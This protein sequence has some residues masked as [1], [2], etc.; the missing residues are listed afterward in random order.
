MA[1]VSILGL[2]SPVV[3]TLAGWVVLH[4]ALTPAQLAPL[5]EAI[6]QLELSDWAVPAEAML[7]PVANT[8]DLRQAFD[9]QRAARVL[10]S[11][12]ETG[13]GLSDLGYFDNML[14]ADPAAAHGFVDH[15]AL[16]D[17]EGLRAVREGRRVGWP[18]ASEHDLALT[19]LLDFYL[20]NIDRADRVIRP[21]RTELP[22]TPVDGTVPLLAFADQ[23]EAVAWIDGEMP[24]L[25]LVIPY[26]GEHGR[27]EHAW[28]IP[29]AL[30]GYLYRNYV[31]T[32]WRGFTE[33]ALASARRLGNRFAEA[34]AAALALVAA[35]QG[36][37][38]CVAEVDHKGTL[39]KLLGGRELSYEP[40]ELAPGVWGMNI[41]PEQALG[42][43]LGPGQGLASGKRGQSECRRRQYHSLFSG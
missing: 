28:Q 41:V 9:K 26:A 24:N 38:V 34:V 10:A 36:R 13:V 37:K 33:V 42:E 18:A 17:P 2:L 5:L 25:R 22:L 23:A 15:D 16:D 7:D 1:R 6:R 20:H 27:H 3:A 29:T 11:M 32:E 35:R 31:W 12:K 19:R 40:S 14:V 43:Y 8:L 21:T 4:Q 30:W 39:S